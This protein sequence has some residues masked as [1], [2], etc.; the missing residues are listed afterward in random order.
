MAEL[1]HVLASYV[2]VWAYLGSA[3]SPAIASGE[4]SV[5]IE[6]GR[7]E[8]MYPIAETERVSL[9][10]AFRLDR[11][12]VTNT[13]FLSF[14]LEHPSWRRDRVSPLF[15]ESLYLSHWSSATE[16][17]QAAPQRAPVVNVS[18]FAAR[19]YCKARGARLP[20]ELEWEYAAAASES[21]RDARRDPAFNA[22]ILS[23]Y[24]RPNAAL[25]ADVGSSAPN[26]WGIYDLHELVWEWVVDFNST[27]ISSDSRGTR[28]AERQTFCGAGATT[29]RDV[30][31]Y[32]SFMRIAFLTSLAA[33]DSTPNLGF[34]CASD[35][36]EG[37]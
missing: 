34:R 11:K 15:A 12:P 23:W 18:W 19:A 2:L 9:V 13:E 27:L 26:A 16:L 1:L 37:S 30:S 24:S 14:V 29:A 3:S 20:S 17:G 35:V 33:R 4:P 31:D 25:L 28:S 10:R 7:F 22:G 5:A 32:A 36:A 21:A 6:G 8:P